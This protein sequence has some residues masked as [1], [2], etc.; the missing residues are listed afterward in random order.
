MSARERHYDEDKWTR[1]LA[2][3]GLCSRKKKYGGWTEKVLE[4]VMKRNT[5]EMLREKMR[6]WSE[7]GEAARAER[8]RAEAAE[9]EAEAAEE[10]KML[11]VLR[12]ANERWMRVHGTLPA[13]EWRERVERAG[14]RAQ[15]EEREERRGRHGGLM[16]ADEQACGGGGGGG[17]TMP[18]MR[19]PA[20]AGPRES[21]ERGRP[22]HAVTTPEDVRDLD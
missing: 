8:A 19:V 3:E 16:V 21:A 11:A 9:E 14:G 6:A 17:D 2:R 1:E 12:E 7:E 10:R 4:E 13:S 5:D 22:Q 20:T 18:F 15:S